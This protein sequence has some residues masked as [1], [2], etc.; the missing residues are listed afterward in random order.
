[1][2]PPRPVALGVCR[3]MPAISRMATTTSMT[4]RA[5]RTLLM[6]PGEFTTPPPRA[7]GRGRAPSLPGRLQALVDRCPVDGVPPGRDVVGALVLVLQVVR[8]LPHV[9][10]EDRH[11]AGADRVVLVGE[12]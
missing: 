5:L 3:R 6:E 1:M 8:V 10:A 2:V 7:R 4:I 12:A 9:H 11:T